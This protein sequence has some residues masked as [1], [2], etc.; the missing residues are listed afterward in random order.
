MSRR[1]VEMRRHLMAAVVMPIGAALVLGA[2]VMMNEL[3][4]APKQEKEI[5]GTIVE[6][7]KAPKPKPE[8][9][10][11]QPKPKPRQAP[12]SPPPPSLAALAS[13]LGNFSVDIPG[14][15]MDGAGNGA[16][17]LVGAETEVVH[18]SDTVDERPVPTRQEPAQY[19]PSLRKRGVTGY[20]LLSVYVEK[21]GQ[22]GDA[23]VLESQP[24]GAFDQSAIDAVRGWSFKPATY[25][26]EAVSGWFE[27]RIAFQLSS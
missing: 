5:T 10:V 1:G 2:T 14:L 17:D 25:K 11:E 18:T 27:Q 7:V 23:R 8:K 6:A 9:K 20:V 24:P 4:E 21:S 22:V 19:P 26:G 13:G 12:R 3:S 15:A 16:L